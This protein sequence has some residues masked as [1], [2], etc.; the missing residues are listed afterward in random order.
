MSRITH[1]NEV[2]VEYTFTHRVSPVHWSFQPSFENL[3]NDIYVY[4]LLVRHLLCDIG[5]T[6]SVRI[7]E[8]FERF[9]A[10]IQGPPAQFCQNYVRRGSRL[11]I[12]T[13]INHWNI[14]NGVQKLIRAFSASLTANPGNEVDLQGLCEVVENFSKFSNRTASRAL[15]IKECRNQH[16][17]HISAA[18][19]GC[20]RLHL[21]KTE[22]KFIAWYVDFT[23]YSAHDIIP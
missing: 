9:A 13:H 16:Y 20:E 19:S 5:Q 22:K 17:A 10:T 1:E 14:N 3:N 7:Q 12:P 2:A 21:D 8:V 6:L 23:S 11:I 18:T 15:Q 4:A